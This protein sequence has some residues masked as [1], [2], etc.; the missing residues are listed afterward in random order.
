MLIS[1]AIVSLLFV[2][3]VAILD[4]TQ[5][6]LPKNGKKYTIEFKHTYVYKN[7][8][9][10]LEDDNCLHSMSEGINNKFCNPI[11]IQQNY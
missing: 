4:V 10:E 9:V 8:L 7:S 6:V 3:P 11:Q 5:R 2:A 1:S